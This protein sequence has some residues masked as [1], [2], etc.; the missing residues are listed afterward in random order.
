MNLPLNPTHWFTGAIA[1]LLMTALPAAAQT[2]TFVEFSGTVDPT[3]EIRSVSNGT[4]IYTLDSQSGGFFNYGDPAQVVINVNNPSTWQVTIS[5]PTA[6]TVQPAEYTGATTFT[7]RYSLSGSNF[8]STSEDL[9][10]ATQFPLIN[11]GETAVAIQSKA[12]PQNP[13]TQPFPAGN[14]T[15]RLTVTISPTAGGQPAPINSGT[16]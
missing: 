12:R 15:M 3:G 8:A 11:S 14:Y 16:P 9:E 7:Y 10:V 1:G 4:M 5:P 13:Q 6:F 2:Q